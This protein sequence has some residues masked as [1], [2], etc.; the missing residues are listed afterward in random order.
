MRR[1]MLW[2][3]PVLVALLVGAAGCGSSTSGTAVPLKM[4]PASELPEFAQKAPPNIREAYRFAIAN[5]EVLQK[6]PCYCGCGAVGHTS[7]YNCY[8]QGVQP[9][10]TVMF[11]NHAYG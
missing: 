11:D 3:V 2:I 9:D 7:N 10:G 1:R 8:A 6:I 4:A 5:P